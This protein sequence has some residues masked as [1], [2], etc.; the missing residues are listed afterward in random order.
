MRPLG[1]PRAS[2]SAISQATV[3]AQ[4]T[5]DTAR[6]ICV[7]SESRALL[8]GSIAGLGTHYSLTIAAANCQT[9]DLLAQEQVEASSKEEVLGT[10]GKAAT[11]SRQT[12]SQCWQR[13]QIL[14]Q[15]RAG[16]F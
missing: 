8:S 9:G 7:R 4:K 5:Q 14:I 16:Q 1:P 3:L 11:L 15:Q 12:Q 6:E 10:L 13:Q 2:Q